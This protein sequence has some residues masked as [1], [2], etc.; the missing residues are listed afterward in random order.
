MSNE[1]Y[2][3]S[4][5]INTVLRENTEDG[6]C[7][8]NLSDHAGRAAKG[9]TAPIDENWRSPFTSLQDAVEFVRDI[10]KPSKPLC[11]VFCAVLDKERY[12][13]HGQVL[14]V[15]GRRDR[16]ADIAVSIW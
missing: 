9:T 12:R 15:K 2:I 8:D 3:K 14:F 4:P 11:K 10:P 5:V 16:A 7:P 13:Q 1:T 6:Y